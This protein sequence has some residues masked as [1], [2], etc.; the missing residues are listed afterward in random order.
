MFALI[1]SVT[2]PVAVDV[3]WHHLCRRH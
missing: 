2:S 1:V 3:K